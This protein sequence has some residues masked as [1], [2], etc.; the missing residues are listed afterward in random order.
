M[1]TSLTVLA[2]GSSG[3]AALLRSDR[4]GLLIDAGIGPRAMI[5]RL[6]GAGFGWHD[7]DAVVLTHTHGDHWSE[8]T[9]AQFL[10]RRVPIFCH[11][12]H[13]EFLTNASMTFG[14][15]R[16]SGLV[17]PFSADSPFAVGD[18]VRLAPFEVAHDSHR[19]FGFRVECR[20]GA[21]GYAADLGGYCGRIVEMLRGVDALALE[22]NHDE[23]MLKSSG[24][25]E[26]LIERILGPAGHLSNRQA[27]ELVLQILAGDRTT[28]PASVIALHLSRE[29]N[30]PDIAGKELRAA[31]ERAGH[32]ARV[33]LAEQS[34]AA[35]TIVAGRNGHE[36]SPMAGSTTPG[37][38]DEP[39]PASR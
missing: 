37:F 10:L 9:L 12:S 33:V 28:R 13:I 3:N 21:I 14:Q 27:C 26:Y 11:D 24:R 31:L 19:T 4:F 22:F 39:S 2:S 8:R 7:I 17:Q 5:R 25:P 18:G 16:H 20:D 32:S 30:R 23:T 36:P 34:R 15:L 6:A 29:C 35:P 1:A 38:W